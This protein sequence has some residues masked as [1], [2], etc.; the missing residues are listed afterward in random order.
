MDWVAD[1]NGANSTCGGGGGAGAGTECSSGRR[2]VGG[3]TCCEEL[4]TKLSVQNGRGRD[5]LG[6]KKKS[7]WESKWERRRVDMR[8]HG[9]TQ[10]DPLKLLDVYICIALYRLVL[11]TGVLRSPWVTSS[12]LHVFVIFHCCE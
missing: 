1:G 3:S 7:E 5:R 8:T 2:E 12:P 6:D 11:V 9:E 4:R 10:G